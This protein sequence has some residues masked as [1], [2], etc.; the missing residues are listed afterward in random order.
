[1]KL[2]DNTRLLD[3]TQK[4]EATCIRTVKSEKLTKDL[5]LLIH[6]PKV[7]RAKY[8]NTEEF[9]DVVANTLKASVSF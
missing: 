5:D 4:L 3:F 8:L 9:I 2:D 1:M 7:T 6:G